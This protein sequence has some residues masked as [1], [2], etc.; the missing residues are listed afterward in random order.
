MTQTAKTG[1]DRQHLQAAADAAVSAYTDRNPRSR[2]MFA[3][4]QQ[5][6]PGG[7]TRSGVHMDPFPFYADRGEGV[8]LVDLDGHRL[9]DFVNNNTALILGHAHPAIVQALQQ[10][11]PKGTGF[12]RPLA[13]EVEMAELLR[14]RIP[15][16]ERLRFCSSGTEAVLNALRTARAFTGRFKTAKF[17]GAY[18]GIDE[19]AMVS[20]LP[21]LGPDLGPDDRPNSVPSTAGLT[22]AVTDDV[23]VL[24]FND[25]AACETIIGDTADDLAAV[26]V[27]PVSTGAGLALPEDGFLKGLLEI[28]HR[29]GALV[30]FDEIVSF[31]ASAGGAQA[32]FDVVPDLTCLGKVVAGGTPGGVFGGRADLM[33][34]YDPTGGPPAIPQSGTF[35]A[36]PFALNAG[37]VTLRAMTD[38][39]YEKLN[40]LTTVV[41]GDLQA[42]FDEAAVPASITVVG[43]IFRLYLLPERPRNY[44]QAAADDNLFQ[45]WLHYSLLNRDIY[46]R[47]GGNLSLP[48]EQEHI[49]HL[50]SAVRDCLRELNQ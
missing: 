40:S 7:N 1:L 38:Q 16:L 32:V 42:V 10:Q 18:H 48:M 30:I 12:P 6:L 25:L 9:L 23:L 35:N 29:A 45:R 28:A 15:S 47:T 26:I 43:S 34:L 5:S 24:P 39:A 2:E 14:E 37:L 33:A 19:H 44:R 22:S 8:H 20:Y 41:A 31:R 46:W 17:E 11:L 3:R 13:L 36:N 27:D 21:P 49:D 4:A 50:I